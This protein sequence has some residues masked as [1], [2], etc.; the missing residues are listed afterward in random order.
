MKPTRGDLAKRKSL[1]LWGAVLP[2]PRFFT[3]FLKVSLLCFLWNASWI[4]VVWKNTKT[5]RPRKAFFFF[6]C[7]LFDTVIIFIGFFFLQIS[8]IPRAT[9]RHHSGTQQPF[10]KS[11]EKK[12]KHQKKVK[13]TQIFRQVIH[14]IRTCLLPLLLLLIQSDPGHKKTLTDDLWAHHAEPR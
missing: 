4:Q 14:T 12:N 9:Y 5:R 6:I 3:F 13:C 1:D 11:Q 7:Q 8:P 10:S 2:S